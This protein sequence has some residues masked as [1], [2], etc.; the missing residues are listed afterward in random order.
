MNLYL[1]NLS[2]NC[3]E[4]EVTA[5][6]KNYGEVTSVNII[7]DRETGRSKGF[8]FVEMPDTGEANAAIEGLNG[9][10]LNGRNITVNQARQREERSSNKKFRGSR[11]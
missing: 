3:G 11:Y 6:F 2:Y 10:L 5:A 9:S 7:S 4:A 8:G 1:G